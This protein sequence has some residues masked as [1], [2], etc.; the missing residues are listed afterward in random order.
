MAFFMKRAIIVHCWS[1]YPEYCWY[2]YVKKQLEVAGFSVQVPA[3]P[4]TDAPREDAWVPFLADC[5]GRP[6]DQ[7]FLIGHSVGCITIMRY[8]ETLKPGEQVGGVVLVA[9]FTD[10]LGFEELKNYFKAPLDFP[11][12]RSKSKN[13]FIAIHSDNDPYVP[14]KF[15]DVLNQ[16]LG[17]EIVIKH[18]MG[19]FSGPIDKEDSCVELPVVVEA[20]NELSQ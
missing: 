6:D 15:A 19:H 16:A 20:V 8:L 18:A 10:D 9:G 13:G 4:D 14:L 17:A 2:P 5:A 3:F 7:L 1:G 11:K 12:I